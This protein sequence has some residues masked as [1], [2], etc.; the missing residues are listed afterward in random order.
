MEEWKASGRAPRDVEDA[1]WARFRAA[2]EKFFSR[3]NKTFSE[4]DAEFEANAAAKEKLL[5][6]AERSILTGLDAAKAALRS[7]QERWEAAGKVPGN[8]SGSSTRLRPSR[9]GSGR[10]RDSHWRRTDPE[11]SARIEQFRAGP[12]VPRQATKAGPAGDERQGEGEAEAQAVQVG[13][14]AR[15]RPELGTAL[16]RGRHRA[17]GS[18]RVTERRNPAV[19]P[20]VID[21]L[22]ALAERIRRLAADR[23]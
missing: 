1:L 21:D 16:R 22:E 13:G 3:R 19:V 23:A 9:T 2:Q 15:D 6:E 14:M 17:G 10:P 12:G 18:R 7:I 20:Q 4:R 8:A 5:T 11:T